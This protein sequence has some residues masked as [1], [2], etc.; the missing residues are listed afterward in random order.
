[1]PSRV[2]LSRSQ[3]P[4]SRHMVAASKLAPRQDRIVAKTTLTVQQRAMR[5]AAHAAI[6]EYLRI[7]RRKM[8]HT[9]I[10][11]AANSVSPFD[12]DDDDLGDDIDLNM[13]DQSAAWPDILGRTILPEI[14][15]IVMGLGPQKLLPSAVTQITAWRAQWMS[16]RTQALMGVPDQITKQIRDAVQDDATTNGP[17]PTSAAN[18]VKN[19][20][21]PDAPTWASRAQ[22]IART[23]TLS[24]NNQGGLASWTA[25]HQSLAP[26]GGQ[27][28]KT[29]LAT[30]DSRTR[31]DHIDIDGTEVGVDDSFSV[32]EDTMNGPGD[33]SA[34]PGNTINCRCTL[35]YRVDDGSDD[36]T[37]DDEAD[38]ADNSDDADDSADDDPD[39]LT[40]APEAPVTAPAIDAPPAGPPQPAD[41]TPSEATSAVT[42]GPQQWSGVLATLD[43]PSSDGRMIS[44][45]GLTIRTLP[46]PLSYQCEGEHGGEPAGSTVIVGRILT[47]EIQG[48]TVV[49]TG[50][51][52]DTMDGSSFAAIEQVAAGIGGVSIDLPVQVVTYMAPGPDGVLIP[53]DPM[54]FMGDPDSVIMVAQ[55]SE[56]AGATIVN[57]PAFADA[58]IQLVDPM[59]VAPN[60][61]LVA[62]A[63]DPQGPLL[64]ATDITFPDGTVVKV[65]DQIDVMGA[66]GADGTVKGT[67]TAIDPDANTVTLT[68]EGQPDPITVDASALTNTPDSADNTSEG[69]SG[70]NT[71]TGVGGPSGGADGVAAAALTAAV[72]FPGLEA[73]HVYPADWFSLPDLE[74]IDRQP[75][76]RVTDDGRVFGLL[77]QSGSC[78]IGFGSECVA[79]PTSPSNYAHFHVGEVKTDQGFLPVGKLTVGGGHADMRLGWQGTVEHYDNAG[80]AAAVVRAYDTDRGIVLAGAL[81][82]NA[83]PEQIAAIRRNDC[84]G[85]W[86][87]IG[88]QRELVAALSVNTG[89]FQLTPRSA[90]AADGRP[91]ALVAAGVVHAE[92]TQ[93]LTLPSGVQLTGQD[94]AVL[95]SAF[96]E[97][98]D[99]RVTTAAERKRR[100]VD[101]DTLRRRVE[102]DALKAT[103]KAV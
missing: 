63:A 81:L 70:T 61:G 90:L 12:D 46:L 41:G 71:G 87:P 4:T 27:V 17:N 76:I 24:A 8:A 79:P 43:A 55:Q 7:V 49:G 78:H 67:V 66:E 21:N 75:H 89:G 101:A 52:L 100:R 30:E 39:A 74:E 31:P 3:S 103:L 64:T 88:G 40:A 84:S 95:A 11:A 16:A 65:G 96:N 5:K 91:L 85:D 44:S 62:D 73:E 13:L 80:S 15:N 57:I 19:L 22:T 68:V 99:Q 9:A 6:Q 58:R 2:V 72:A 60:T 48:N 77:A 23:E 47:A 38:D 32:G 82:P 26:M 102:R 97:V 45:S 56:L 1:M 53:V 28:Y 98:A 33:E 29:W 59:T 20:L 69:A 92:P 14:S 34:D 25:V 93:G 54:Q 42:P 37:G 18:I 86:R 10:R 94:I 50:D 36:D 83:T 51:F 35:T